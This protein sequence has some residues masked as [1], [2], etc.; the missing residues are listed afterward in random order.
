MHP[1]HQK[2]YQNNSKGMSKEE[3][4]DDVCTLFSASCSCASLEA[5][6]RRLCCW[7]GAAAAVMVVEP[8]TWPDNPPPSHPCLLL[9]PHRRMGLWPSLLCLQRE[10]Q[11]R[12]LL[13]CLHREYQR[14]L[15]LPCLLPGLP[16]RKF[17]RSCRT[18]WWQYRWTVVR[19]FGPPAR[20]KTEPLSGSPT[21]R[22]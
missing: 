14:R 15:L 3:G 1:P 5:S 6:W 2:T 22:Q 18:C 16:I 13:P 20:P 4:I 11:R 10:Y 8:T 19:T 7:L 17:G 12:F 21:F 9:P